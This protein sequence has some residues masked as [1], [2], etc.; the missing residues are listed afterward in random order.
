MN[1]KKYTHKAKKQREL[2]VNKT[3][4][5][6]IK[7][8]YVIGDKE[9]CN[10]QDY[11]IEDDIMYV[12]TED[13]YNSLPLKV[14]KAYEII[15]QNFDYDYIFK[16]DDDIKLTRKQFIS[17]L[18]EKLKHKTIYYGGFRLNSPKH[19]S[20]W[21]LKHDCLPKDIVIEKTIYCTG[22]FYFLHKEAVVNVLESK[23][24]FKGRYFEDHCIGLFLDDKYKENCY[25]FDTFKYFTEEIK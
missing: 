17:D 21:Y 20:P 10:Q 15:N 22:R 5:V 1:C 3:L 16:T 12:N 2:W 9:K 14:I 25:H 6:N 24:K 13:D 8:Y 19:V 23:D 11:V 7:Y 18:Q 4:P